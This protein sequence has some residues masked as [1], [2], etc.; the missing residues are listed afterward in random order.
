MIAETGR[1][2][3]SAVDLDSIDDSMLL[4]SSVVPLSSVGQAA[5]PALAPQ[6]FSNAA[7]SRRADMNVIESRQPELRR[8]PGSRVS[9][10]DD[11]KMPPEENSTE[12]NGSAKSRWRLGQRGVK[13][14]TALQ[15]DFQEA[16]QAAASAPAA[17]AGNAI[18]PSWAVDEEI[19]DW[20]SAPTRRN[21]AAASVLNAPGACAGRSSGLPAAVLTS[22]STA[23]LERPFLGT[24]LEPLST[25]GLRRGR[26]AR[27]GS[28]EGQYT[29]TAPMWLPPPEVD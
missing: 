9:F 18:K 16:A 5:L 6:K 22:P 7:Q 11:A 1:H 12:R 29:S 25:T 15:L 23:R 14:R 28:G 13:A 10:S 26:G 24:S 2:Y 20:A 21:D 19:P 17:R 3:A 4:R 8:P 27:R